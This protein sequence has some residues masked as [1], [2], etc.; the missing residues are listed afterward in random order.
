MVNFERYTDRAR[1]AVVLA[2]EHAR[3]CEHSYV[4]PEHLLYGCAA[5]EGGVAHQAL[6]EVGV[7]VGL[8]EEAIDTLP[9]L[10]LASP[11]VVPSATEGLKRDMH[12]A[13]LLSLKM[14]H[15]YVGTEHLL[16]ALTSHRTP[17]LGW[18]NSRG[19]GA[20]KLLNQLGVDHLI[21]EA[22][23]RRLLA[24]YQQKPWETVR[25]IAEAIPVQLRQR[26]TREILSEALL[27]LARIDQRLAVVEQRLGI[28]ELPE[29]QPAAADAET[30]TPPEPA[31]EGTGAA[32]PQ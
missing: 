27:R 8:L 3:A 4:G 32:T 12:A 1:R 31:G 19:L 6:I 14:G 30:P 29:Q 20:G 18:E 24:T 26:D 15:N 10:R 23:V 9:G 21:L 11:P 7:T 17:A 13:A 25:P 2:F 28:A 16:L 22:V 5:E